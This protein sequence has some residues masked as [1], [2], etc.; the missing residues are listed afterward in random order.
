MSRLG[1][2]LSVGARCSVLAYPWRA[3]GPEELGLE[4]K[5]AGEPRLFS[6][7]MSE[8]NEFTCSSES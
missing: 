3:A 5:S 6:S 1:Y 2:S 7:N 8:S 4:F